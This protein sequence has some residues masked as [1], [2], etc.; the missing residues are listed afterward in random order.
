MKR[1]NADKFRAFWKDIT[2][3]VCPH[4]FISNKSKDYQ[5]KKVSHNTMVTIKWSVYGEQAS[6]VLHTLYSSALDE[7]NDGY[8]KAYWGEDLS[9]IQ[10]LT[11]HAR[12]QRLKRQMTEWQDDVKFNN[13]Y[14]IIRNKA[15]ERKAEYENMMVAA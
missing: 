9:V 10:R 13:L 5:G 14:E 8:R 2:T 12:K 15:V 11:M 6:E 1:A 4:Q 3:T 7:V